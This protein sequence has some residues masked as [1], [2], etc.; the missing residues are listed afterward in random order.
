M[1]RYNN[2]CGNFN[3]EFVFY[4]EWADPEIIYKGFVFSEPMIQGSLYEMFI[5]EYGAEPKTDSAFVAYVGNNVQNFLDDCLIDID[6]EYIRKNSPM[7]FEFLRNAAV[8]DDENNGA[9]YWDSVEKYSD[10]NAVVEHFTGISFTVD[11]FV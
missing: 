5:D 6:I 11:D 3:I 9:D 1:R 8:I 2:Y 4:N 7:N 10:D